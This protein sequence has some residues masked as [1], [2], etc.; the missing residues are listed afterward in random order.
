[1]YYIK[2][3]MELTTNPEITAALLCMQGRVCFLN[4][5]YKKCIDILTDALQLNHTNSDIT[6]HWRASAYC[7]QVCV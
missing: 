4:R 1:M 7:E 3:A 6:Y 2:N 5:E